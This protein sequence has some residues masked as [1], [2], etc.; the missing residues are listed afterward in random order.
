MR[1]MFANCLYSSTATAPFDE[2]HHDIDLSSSAIKD[3]L[4]SM[5]SADGTEDVALKNLE[6][7]GAL[8]IAASWAESGKMKRKLNIMKSYLGGAEKQFIEAV[9]REDDNSSIESSQETNVVPEEFLRVDPPADKSNQV[10]QAQSSRSVPPPQK[11]PNYG[12]ATW[13]QTAASMA[14]LR[15]TRKRKKYAESDGDTTED[16]DEEGRARTMHIF[17]VG[18]SGLT[19]LP[20]KL[21]FTLLEDS[22][23][24]VSPIKN[25]AVVQPQEQQVPAKKIAIH[26]AQTSNDELFDKT[27]SSLRRLQENTPVSGLSS[28]RETA[29]HEPPTESTPSVRHKPMPTPPDSSRKG[30]KPGPASAPQ[31][32]QQHERRPSDPK[33]MRSLSLVAQP[34]DIPFIDLGNLAKRRSPTKQ[35]FSLSRE[36]G[37]PPQKRRNTGDA[38]EDRRA[39]PLVT[40]ASTSGIQEPALRTNTSASA[41]SLEP[42]KLPLAMDKESILERLYKAAPQLACP[43]FLAKRRLRL[44]REQSESIQTETVESSQPESDYHSPVPETQLLSP[45]ASASVQVLSRLPSED[46]FSAMD[47]DPERTRELTERFKRELAMGKRPGLVVPQLQCTRMR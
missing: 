37:A 1:A 45:T 6:G 29:V 39:E 32:E 44:A 38:S 42:K 36:G 3:M 34:Q 41:S 9:L 7:E 2:F 33:R 16:S 19:E 26:G 43:E 22:S 14:R 21:P 20:D 46:D 12:K 27:S 31:D 11:R 47:I 24:P 13:E 4:D 35:R 17:L 23:P 8:E 10:H 25:A 18:Q 28:K 30:I 15:A 5:G 40:L